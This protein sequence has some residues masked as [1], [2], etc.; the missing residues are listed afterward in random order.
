MGVLIKYHNLGIYVLINLILEIWWEWELFQQQQQLT[1]GKAL[2]VLA[3]ISP[4]K[5]PILRPQTEQPFACECAARGYHISSHGT[6]LTMLFAH[7]LYW[8]AA[9]LEIPKLVCVKTKEEHE[10][11]DERSLDERTLARWKGTQAGWRAL[12]KKHTVQYQIE[13]NGVYA[14]AKMPSTSSLPSSCAIPA[15]T[16]TTIPE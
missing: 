7:W 4:T 8:S 10:V 15:G 12:Q 14:Y 3:T 16:P 5:F 6:C 9:L 13:E 11:S 1:R 2:A